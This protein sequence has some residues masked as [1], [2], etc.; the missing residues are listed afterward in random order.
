MTLFA[1]STT[2][3]VPLVQNNVDNGI[4]KTF[5]MD[6]MQVM[7]SMILGR[8]ATVKEQHKGMKL[9]FWIIN[10]THKRMDHTLKERSVLPGP[11]RFWLLISTM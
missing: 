8:I 5:I 7:S 3:T 1:H 9:E 6:I 4:T 11:I 10:R 2:T